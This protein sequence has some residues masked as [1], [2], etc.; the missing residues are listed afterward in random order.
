MTHSRTDFSSSQR[1]ERAARL[2]GPLGAVLTVGAI[3][4]AIALSPEF[5]WTASA[6]SDLGVAADPTVRLLFNGGLIAGGVVAVAY[7]RALGRHS[8]A[9]AVGYVLAIVAMALVGAFPSDTPLHFPVAVAFFLLATATVVIDGWRRRTTAAGR[10]ALALAAGHA[11]GWLLWG[12][13]VRPGPGLALPELGGVVMF[14]L[15]VLAL[16]PPVRGP[17]A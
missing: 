5:S 1:A 4:A 6:L 17:G 2:S 3:A 7:G 13:E 15:W 11:L 14:G 9:V 16:A 8:T 12:F 10:V